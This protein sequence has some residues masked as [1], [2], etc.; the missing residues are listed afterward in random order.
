[1]GFFVLMIFFVL[2]AVGLRTHPSA[3]VIFGFILAVD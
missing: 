1:L 2:D 3:A